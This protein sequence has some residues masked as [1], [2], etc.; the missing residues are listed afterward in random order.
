M[1]RSQHERVA[2]GPIDRGVDSAVMGSAASSTSSSQTSTPAPETQQDSYDGRLPLLQRLQYAISR[3]DFAGLIAAVEAADAAA[4]PS[5]GP[6]TLSRHLLFSA[7][8]AG[9]AP[10][11]GW[12]LAQHGVQHEQRRQQL[13]LQAVSTLVDNRGE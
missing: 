10:V 5:Q 7:V 2:G 8:R 9:H 3:G 12:L 6:T 11:V 13:Q 1:H 4:G